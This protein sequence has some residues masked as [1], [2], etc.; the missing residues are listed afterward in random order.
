MLFDFDEPLPKEGF[1]TNAD[2]PAI[3]AIEVNDPTVV[4]PLPVFNVDNIVKY[5]L[6]DY[7]EFENGLVPVQQQP[8]SPA[9]PAT[10]Q[11]NLEK[12]PPPVA[13][14]SI[15]RQR[16]V[17]PLDMPINEV[18]KQRAEERKLKMHQHNFK[19]RNAHKLEELEKK[20]AYQRQGIE[21]NKTSQETDRSRTTL[22]VDD[23][24]K[25]QFRSN[26]NS[27]LHDNVD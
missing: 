17:D 22:H 8:A 12:T 21:L 13:P 25:M 11:E 27:F 15:Q 10:N 24:D 1:Q 14:S 18:L 19:F 26:N 6:D 3:D 7:M 5:T 16:P 9:S 20:P 23:K 4:V 2:I